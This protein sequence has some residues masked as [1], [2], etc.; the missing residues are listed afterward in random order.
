[1][2][3]KYG[4]TQ[5]ECKDIFQRGF[6]MLFGIAAMISKG[7]IKVS[8]EE[9]VDMVQRTFIQMIGSEKGTQI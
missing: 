6:F 3:E 1:M 4:M 9:A 7:K 5:E 2:G 8:N